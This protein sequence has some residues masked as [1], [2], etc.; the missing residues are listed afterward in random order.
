[1]TLQILK[2]ET[3]F[4]IIIYSKDFPVSTRIKEIFKLNVT[5]DIRKLLTFGKEI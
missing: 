2:L 1:M 5:K 4:P 3:Y